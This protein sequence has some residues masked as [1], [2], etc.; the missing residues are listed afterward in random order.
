MFI[1]IHYAIRLNG[2]RLDRFPAL[3]DW[4]RRIGKRSSSARVLRRSPKPIARCLRSSAPEIPFRLSTAGMVS[5]V[6]G[7]SRVCRPG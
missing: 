5:V 6:D 2:P 4:Y 3:A 1:T 7:P